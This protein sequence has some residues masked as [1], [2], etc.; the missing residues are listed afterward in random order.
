MLAHFAAYQGR[1]AAE[2][3]AHPAN[4]KRANNTVVPSS[5]FTDPEIATVG[6]SEEEALAKGTEIRVSKFDFLGSGMARIMDEFEGFIKIIS[7]K[8][9]G[10]IL[11]AGIIGP[12]ATE[13][14]GILTL[15]VTHRLSLAQLRDTIFAHPTISE[16]IG[17]VLS[18]H[19]I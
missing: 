14:V 4:P 12:R 7:D 1:V 5:I 15:A 16:A 6:L 2:N 19:G 18:E 3:I 11:G 9:N 10:Q 13:I 8:K 17:E